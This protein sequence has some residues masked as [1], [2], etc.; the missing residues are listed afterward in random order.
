MPSAHIMICMQ[1]AFR[2]HFVAIGVVQGGSHDAILA[3]IGPWRQYARSLRNECSIASYEDIIKQVS[4]FMNYVAA[5]K[6]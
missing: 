3:K 4:I 1:L 6:S 2:I 5:L